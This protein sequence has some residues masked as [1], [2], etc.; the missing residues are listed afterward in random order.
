MSWQNSNILLN[1]KISSDVRRKGSAGFK[2]S[3]SSFR[4]IQFLKNGIPLMFNI[5]S[6]CLF[7]CLKKVYIRL[8]FNL[9]DFFFLNCYKGN[10]DDR[11]SAVWFEFYIKYK[12]K[13]KIMKQKNDTKKCCPSGSPYYSPLLDDYE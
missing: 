7:N 5:W 1:P 3:F 12:K 9:K 13:K 6:L 4:R 11:F 8:H 2:I 10:E